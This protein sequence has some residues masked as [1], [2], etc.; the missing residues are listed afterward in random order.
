MSNREQLDIKPSTDKPRA[1]SAESTSKEPKT[2]S[3]RRATTVEETG[4]RKSQQSSP[5]ISGL[6][7]R[8]GADSQTP[9]VGSLAN[10]PRARVLKPQCTSRPPSTPTTPSK[11]EQEMP[12]PAGPGI[13]PPLHSFGDVIPRSPA[14]RGRWPDEGCLVRAAPPFPPMLPPSAGHD[15]GPPSAETSDETTL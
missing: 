12:L 6:L 4:P 11:G 1:D 8:D 3:P 14:K 7:D 9:R 15:D 13:F 2:A 10:G 5:C